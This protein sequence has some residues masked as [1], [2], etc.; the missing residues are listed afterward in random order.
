VDRRHTW[1][2]G[3]AHSGAAS[4]TIDTQPNFQEFTMNKT[5]SACLLSLAT[6]V[7]VGASAA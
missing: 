4:A 7:S 6:V 1:N 5:L 2:T 3:A